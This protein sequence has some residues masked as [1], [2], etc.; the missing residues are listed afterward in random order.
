V[1][2]WNEQKRVNVDAR[3]G[4]ILVKRHNGNTTKLDLPVATHPPRWPS[5]VADFEGE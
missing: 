1:M 3:S 5:R 2:W 4:R